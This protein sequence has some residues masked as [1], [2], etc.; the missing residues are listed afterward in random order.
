MPTA[1]L[2]GDGVPV[3]N[4]EGE[5][6]L[7]HAAMEGHAEAHFVLARMYASSSPVHSYKLLLRAA[8]REHV[9]AMCQL[10][11]YYIRGVG[12]KASVPLAI[13]W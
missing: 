13:K 11:S 1:Y 2:N 12:T 9:D 5:R 8:K 3:D 4:A 6:M 10:A 7:Q